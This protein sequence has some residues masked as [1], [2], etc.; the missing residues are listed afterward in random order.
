MNRGQSWFSEEIQS[1]RLVLGAKGFRDWVYQNHVDQSVADVPLRQSRPHAKIP[2][3]LIL[4]HVGFVY[5]IPVSKVRLGHQGKGNE[6]RSMAIYLAR[7]ITGVPQ[8]DLVKWF[9]T[10][11]RYAIAKN[12]QRFKECMGQ[13]KALMRLAKEVESQINMNGR[14][15]G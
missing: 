8:K 9:K 7:Q 15:E 13:N 6:A 1:N 5:N 2:I 10:S 4:E 14:S 12:I 11:N 3:K